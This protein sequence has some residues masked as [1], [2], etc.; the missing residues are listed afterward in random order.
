MQ[1]QSVIVWNSETNQNDTL[2]IDQQVIDFAK[3]YKQ[4]QKNFDILYLSSISTLI[5]IAIVVSLIKKS[6][7]K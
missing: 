2:V 6:R 1:D 3:N 4:D 7:R 5:V